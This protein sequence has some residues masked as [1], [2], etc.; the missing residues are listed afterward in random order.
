MPTAF[1]HFSSLAFSI[2]QYST[3]SNKDEREKQLALSQ[4]NDFVWK[5][6]SSVKAFVSIS[7]R[8]RVVSLERDEEY[9]AF[10]VTETWRTLHCFFNIYLFRVCVM[11]LVVVYMY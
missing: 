4:V 6:D 5:T 8:L 7:D 11:I 1:L 10:R 2:A 3:K 9:G